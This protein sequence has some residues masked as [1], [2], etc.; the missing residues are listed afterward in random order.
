MVLLGVSAVQPLFVDDRQVWT[1]VARI[2]GAF[3][4]GYLL[5]LL[6]RPEP[7]TESSEP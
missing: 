3:V 2:C 7:A 5:W 1:W 6:L 4:Y